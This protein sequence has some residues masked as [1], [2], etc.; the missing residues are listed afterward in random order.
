MWMELSFESMLIMQ[1]SDHVGAAIDDAFVEG[2]GLKQLVQ[3]V[4]LRGGG[5][6]ERVVQVEAGVAPHALR[7]DS[8]VLGAEDKTE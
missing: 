2:D 5:K 4:A 8:E 3:L 1:V 7:G 6:V